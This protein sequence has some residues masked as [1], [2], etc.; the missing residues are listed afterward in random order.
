MTSR[1]STGARYRRSAVYTICRA[2]DRK[3]LVVCALVDASRQRTS[4]SRW[5]YCFFFL[6][7]IY[8]FSLFYFFESLRARVINVRVPEGSSNVLLLDSLFISSCISFTSYLTLSLSVALFLS[9]SRLFSL[10]YLAQPFMQIRRTR[11]LE[12][13][14]VITFAAVSRA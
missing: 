5:Y 1:S 13:V 12:A 11:E 2:R 14:I 10:L 4:T 7:F 3:E 6:F 9:V 8:F